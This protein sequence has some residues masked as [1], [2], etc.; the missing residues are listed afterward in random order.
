MIK[1]DKDDDDDHKFAKREGVC[2][3]RAIFRSTVSELQLLKTFYYWTEKRKRS[4]SVL[5]ST[6]QNAYTER[7]FRIGE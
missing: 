7:V 2:T 3:S 1:A 4:D 6:Q 5:W